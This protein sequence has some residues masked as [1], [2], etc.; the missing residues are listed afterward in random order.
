MKDVTIK[1]EIIGL[2]NKNFCCNKPQIFYDN[3]NSMIYI[4]IYIVAIKNL[5][6]LIACKYRLL[7]H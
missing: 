3:F 7:I 4:Y 5:L 6:F 1:F 2:Y